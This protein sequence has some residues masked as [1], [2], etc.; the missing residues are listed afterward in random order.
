M[1]VVVLGQERIRS[2]E[3]LSIFKITSPLLYDSVRLGRQVAYY[4]IQGVAIES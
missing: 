2:Y 4:T 1:N 3:K